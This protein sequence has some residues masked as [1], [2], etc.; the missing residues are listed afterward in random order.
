MV[1]II[2]VLIMIVSKRD[3][4]YFFFLRLLIKLGRR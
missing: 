4:S 3:G 1:I 2:H